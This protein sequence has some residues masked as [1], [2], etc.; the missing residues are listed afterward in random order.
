[1]AT[2]VPRVSAFGLPLWLQ[3]LIEVAPVI[4]TTIAKICERS[5]ETGKA[6]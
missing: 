3:I 4:I 6:K 5:A 2:K 1:M